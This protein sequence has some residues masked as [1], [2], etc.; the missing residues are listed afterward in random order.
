MVPMRVRAVR[1]R[2]PLVAIGRAVPAV[3]A[4]TRQQLAAAFGAHEKQVSEPP[5]AGLLALLAQ[6]LDRRFGVAALDYER[7][8]LLQNAQ[9]ATQERIRRTR[10]NEKSG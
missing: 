2:M 10:R 8:V 4:A 3:A 6:R 7:R 5:Q 1:R 9:A